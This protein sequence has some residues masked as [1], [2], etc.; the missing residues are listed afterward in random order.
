MDF[1]NNIGMVP[2]HV[3]INGAKEETLDVWKETIQK[4]KSIQTLTDSHSQWQ[5]RGASE[6][7]GLKRMLKKF[8]CISGSTQRLWCYILDFIC[9]IKRIIVPWDAQNARL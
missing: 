5:N 7:R 6:I 2:N 9:T 8:T 1:M 3:V 4:Y